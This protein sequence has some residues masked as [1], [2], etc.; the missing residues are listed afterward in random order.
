[1]TCVN[2]NFKNY[3]SIVNIFLCI[4][5]NNSNIINL[6]WPGVLELKKIF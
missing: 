2:N 4:V 3:S 5:T 1:M 6:Y